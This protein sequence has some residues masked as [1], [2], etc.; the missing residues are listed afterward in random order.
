MVLETT[1]EFSIPG[2]KY[3]A[4]RK[5]RPDKDGTSRWS[6]PTG[7]GHRC[8]PK[9][10][11]ADQFCTQKT[12]SIPRHAGL[13]LAQELQYKSPE[14]RD[15]YA[16]RYTIESGN[17]KLKRS[18]THGLGDPERRRLRGRSAQFIL[19]SL[20]VVS[21]NIQTIRSFAKS[22][23]NRLKAEVKRKNRRRVLFGFGTMNDDERQEIE[24]E[25]SE[26]RE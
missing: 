26:A 22:V 19:A 4:V 14:W 7:L 8:D 16:R 23:K 11:H 24:A 6:H 18:S 12:I 20:L 25:R 13:K 15:M 10:K 2:V 1:F 3:A 9:R 17:A 21:A 5:S